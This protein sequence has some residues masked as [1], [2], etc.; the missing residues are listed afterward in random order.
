MKKLCII[1]GM[2]PLATAE[3]YRR[4]VLASPAGCDQ[5]HIESL[6]ISDAAMPDRS[7]AIRLGESG[8]LLRRFACHFAQA[9]AWG[10]EVVAIPC[11]TSHF[12]MDAFREM[13]DLE[14][15][16]MPML[17]AARAGEHPCVLATEGTYRS[18]V[19]ARRLEMLGKVQYP[20]SLADRRVAMETIYAVKRGAAP[21]HRSF[22][23]FSDLIERMRKE[24]G[25]VILACTELSLF[26]FSEPEIFDAMDLLAGE[27][28]RICYEK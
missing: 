10:A 22:P 27:V 8:E 4:V 11:N 6:I 15:I 17:A 19:Y 16:D 24:A 25:D 18:G 21:D 9:K 1:G 28:V 12:Y 23:E 13:T 3:F 7:M 26:S 2:G 14:I 20:M 5:E